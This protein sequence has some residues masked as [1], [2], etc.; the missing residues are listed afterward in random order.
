VIAVHFADDPDHR[1][2]RL[3]VAA[4]H[5]TEGDNH[6]LVQTVDLQ[7]QVFG[8]RRRRSAGKDLPHKD[9]HSSQRHPLARREFRDRRAPVEL[10]DDPFL[11]RVS[12]RPSFAAR[13]SQFFASRRRRLRV[14][15]APVRHMDLSSIEHEMQTTTHSGNQKENVVEF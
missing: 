15:V 1:I 4:S 3:E 7:R 13:L 5:R 6:R 11:A 8:G 2:D 10:V 12:F 9:L 14:G